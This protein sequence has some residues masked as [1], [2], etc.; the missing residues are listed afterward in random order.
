MSDEELPDF[1]ILEKLLR[2][3]NEK[4]IGEA[5]TSYQ[6]ENISMFPL[7]RK[8]LTGILGKAEADEQ[9]RNPRRSH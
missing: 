5:L 1:L 6:A 2:K 8:L 9:N 3:P 4:L 7:D